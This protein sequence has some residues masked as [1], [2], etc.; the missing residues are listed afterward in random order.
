[1]IALQEQARRTRDR[2][3]RELDRLAP[4]EEEWERLRTTFDTLEVAVQ[5]P[6]LES[7]ADHWHGVLEI[8]EFPVREHEGYAKPFPEQVL[9]F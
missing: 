8:P 4:V 6:A 9:L 1:M 3:D 2:L 7:L 5:T